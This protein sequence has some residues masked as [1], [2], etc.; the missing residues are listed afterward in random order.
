MRGRMRKISPIHQDPTARGWNKAKQRLYG[1]GFSHAISTQ[2]GNSFT[3]TY[4][5]INAKQN[6]AG[7]IARVQPLNPQHHTLS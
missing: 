7:T 3:L 5:Q 6:L 2:Q 4:L 1:C